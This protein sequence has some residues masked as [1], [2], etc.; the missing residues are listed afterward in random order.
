[1]DHILC[2]TN[3]SHHG[4]ILCLLKS[5]QEKQ[6]KCGS[7]Q[8]YV[9]VSIGEGKLKIYLIISTLKLAAM[10]GNLVLFICQRYL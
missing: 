6:D 2:D 3:V 10:T 4:L 1:M 7:L 5:R 9:V 8:T